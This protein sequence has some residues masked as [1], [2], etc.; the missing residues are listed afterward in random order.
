MDRV[1]LVKKIAAL[2]SQDRELFAGM[3]DALAQ[4]VENEEVFFAGFDP[5]MGQEPDAEE[6]SKVAAADAASNAF[7]AVS[8]TSAS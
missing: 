1:D 4:Y 6:V 3:C 8:A 2:A 7:A 5:E